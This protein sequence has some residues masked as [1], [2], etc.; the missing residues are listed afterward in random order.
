MEQTLGIYIH[1]PFCEHKCYYC[2]FYSIVAGA[3]AD[4]A[5]VV[6]SYLVSL[7]K[8]ALLYQSQWAGHYFNSLFLGGGTPTILPAEDLAELVTFS[9]TEL[10]LSPQAEITVEA[11]PNT[12]S[13]EGLKLLGAA[14]VNRI[15]LG[16]QAFQDSLLRTLGRLHSAD[17][18]ISSVKR[19]R[20]AGIG[21][22]NLDLM[23]GLPGQTMGDWVDTLEQALALEPEHFSCYSLILEEGTP[24]ADWERA[25]LLKLPSHD[26]Q[27]EMFETAIR[28]LTAA[29]YVHYEISNFSR[30]GRQSRHN[31]LYWYN[32]PF[33]GLGPGATGY[34]GRIRYTNA[35]DVWGYIHDIGEGKLPTRSSISVTLEEEM[36]ETMMVGM[37]L[38][39][40]VSEESF[41]LRYGVSYFD[42]Y[43]EQ[44]A[45]LM[46]RGLVEHTD[47]HL[48]VTKRG[49]FLENLVSGAF[50]R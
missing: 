17:Q 16:A 1:V 28:I 39:A 37:R 30:P 21:N 24:F 26:L 3:H 6:S 43:P 35:P 49:L 46:A 4:F 10:P 22:V 45:D 18:I 38:L 19:I 42:V 2:D 5:G 29:G 7:R 34:L 36:D 47:G 15:S 31:L 13:Y 14:G 12:L 8:E 41:R 50:L 20:R 44:I 27:A 11:N 23:F 32:Q 48:R 25:G 40:G 33:L 9:R